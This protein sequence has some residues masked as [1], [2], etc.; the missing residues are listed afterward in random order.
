MDDRSEVPVYE[1]RLATTGSPAALIVPFPLS[2]WR[3]RSRAAMR[4]QD[5]LVTG[6]GRQ[7]GEALVVD[8]RD[9][10][11][12]SLS[13]SGTHWPDDAGPVGPLVGGDARR[14][15]QSHPARPTGVQVR[16]NLSQVRSTSRR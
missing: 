10:P 14:P 3:A 1:F 8:L 12:A 16:T 15:P 6:L 9:Q 5:E 7:D 4:G 2:R 13:S 11:I